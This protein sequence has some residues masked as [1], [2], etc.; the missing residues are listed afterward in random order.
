MRR[1][2]SGAVLAG[3]RE[4]DADGWRLATWSAPVA[5]QVALGLWAF[6]AWASYHWRILSSAG[7]F[8]TIATVAALVVTGAL[9]LSGKSPRRRG[10]GLAIIASGVTVLACMLVFVLIVA[11]ISV[12]S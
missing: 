2:V 4:L 9:L 10:F 3:I 7:V 8:W 5:M 11:L 1:G 6:I 12:N